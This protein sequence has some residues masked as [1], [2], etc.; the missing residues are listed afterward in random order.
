MIIISILI[1]GCCF[2]QMK[3]LSKANTDGKQDDAIIKKAIDSL[4]YDLREDSATHKYTSG[5]FVYAPSNWFKVLQVSGQGCG[6]YCNPLNASWIFYEYGGKLYRFNAGLSPVKEIFLLKE[7]K[8]RKEFIITTAN[9]ARPRGI[10]AGDTRSC[11]LLVF[12]DSSG[13]C[14]V[15]VDQIAYFYTGVLC[16]DQLQ[17]AKVSNDFPDMQY[18]PSSK[19]LSY[20]YYEFIDEYDKCFEIK[21]YY[22]YSKGKFINKVLIDKRP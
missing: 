14:R 19:T 4:N 10:E 22:Y 11:C 13:T 2:S 21:G 1:A 6:A 5:S 17:K 7:S 16:S 18:N 8:G 20:H 9:W 12:T 3:P 15:R